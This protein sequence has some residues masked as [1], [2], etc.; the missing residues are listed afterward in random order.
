M[1]TTLYSG[2]LFF[3]RYRNAQVTS[4]YVSRLPGRRHYRH[5]ARTRGP[6]PLS[7]LW[8]Q[9]DL[10]ANK[11]VILLWVVGPNK[12]LEK[13]FARSTRNLGRPAAC[14]TCSERRDHTVIN[15]G[16]YYDDS[17]C[18]HVVPNVIL[19]PLFL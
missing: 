5:Y 6:R 13:Q 12:S 4:G 9:T 3:S 2:L 10:D 18:A 15:Y 1:I 11:L 19:W 16:N 14:I 8:G 7:R 17:Y